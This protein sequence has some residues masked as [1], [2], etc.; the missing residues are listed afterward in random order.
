ML[1]AN[2]CLYREKMTPFDI[3]GTPRGMLNNNNFSVLNRPAPG[4]LG[5]S[6]LDRLIRLY[7]P[8]PGYSDRGPGYSGCSG[9]VPG[10]SGTM[11]YSGHPHPGL[12]KKAS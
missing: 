11:G 9:Q 6:R 8:R 1:I 7:R 4:Y 5:H 3:W 2:I 10:Y 12:N